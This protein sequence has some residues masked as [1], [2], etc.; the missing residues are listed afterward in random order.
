VGLGI[1]LKEE[2][3]RNVNR[4]SGICLPAFLIF[5]CVI[6]QVGIER[7]KTD[8]QHHNDFINN[9]LQKV[10]RYVNVGSTVLTGYGVY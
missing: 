8:R 3:K 2:I 1:V 9:E 6:L 7:F 10:K 4:V 5:S